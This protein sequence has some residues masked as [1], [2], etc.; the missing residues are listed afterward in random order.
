MT[1]YDCGSHDFTSSECSQVPRQSHVLVSHNDVTLSARN[2]P[3]NSFGFF[4]TSQTQGFVANP[5][6]SGGNLCLAGAIGRYVGAGQIQNSGVSGSF[7]LE[8][9]LATTPQPI[10]PVSVM[11]G[12]TWNYQAW[13]RDSTMG[14]A[15]SNFTDA[16]T[17]AY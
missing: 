2:L 15:S 5:A 8:L 3:T 12:E 17:V 9:D 16:V 7:A 11:A 4:I 14:N 6:G 13:H 1:S 10:Q